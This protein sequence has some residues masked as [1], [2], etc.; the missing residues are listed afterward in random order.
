MAEEELSDMDALQ[1]SDQEAVE[2]AVV[3]AYILEHFSK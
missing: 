2:E 3:R 1:L